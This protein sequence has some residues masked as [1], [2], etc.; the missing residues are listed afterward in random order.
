MSTQELFSNVDFYREDGDSG[1]FRARVESIEETPEGQH[2]TCTI[3]TAR[4]IGRV[5]EGNPDK[6]ET[7]N[8]LSKGLAS[9]LLHLGSRRMVLSACDLL[10]EVREETVTGPVSRWFFTIRGNNGE[11]L[12][13]QGP[14]EGYAARGEA[15][16]D[17]LLL[18]A[19]LLHWTAAGRPE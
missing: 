17:L 11:E 9:I 14:V 6:H 10:R 18:A 15:E 12:L 13:V 2:E 8:A 19:A 5:S 1:D 4:V 16:R 7:L 3:R